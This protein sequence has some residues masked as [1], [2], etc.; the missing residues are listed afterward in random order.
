[1]ACCCERAS[2]RTLWQEAV[3]PSFDSMF[4]SLCP[5]V[6]AQIKPMLLPHVRRLLM[7]LNELELSEIAL[8]LTFFCIVL[9][10]SFNSGR[11]T[12]RAQPWRP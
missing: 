3:G 12:I 4:S 11:D 8:L 6:Q 5:V 2:S 7:Q 1:M 10:L 9:A